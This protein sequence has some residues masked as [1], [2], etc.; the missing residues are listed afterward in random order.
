MGMPGA[1]VPPQAGTGMIPGVGSATGVVP[2]AGMGAMGGLVNPSNVNVQT[3][4]PGS[5]IIVNHRHRSRSRERRSGRRRSHSVDIIQTGTPGMGMGYGMPG[6]G[7]Y[8]A[9]GGTPVGVGMGV[10][11]NGMAMGGM[12]GIGGAYNPGMYGGMNAGRVYSG[13]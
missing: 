8:G 10:P 12:G 7:S 9:A 5:T 11:A 2:G 3:I 6:G 1:G 4:P 13:L